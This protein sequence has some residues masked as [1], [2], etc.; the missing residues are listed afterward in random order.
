MSIG[1]NRSPTNSTLSNRL[2]T[3]SR[4]LTIKLLIDLGLTASLMAALA[5]H[6][7]GGPAHEV[8]GLAM[9]ILLIA[10]NVLNWR[11]YKNLGARPS[12]PRQF[13]G[14]TVTLVLLA[15]TVALLISSIIVSRVVFDF[16]LVENGFL[17]RQIHT[18][19]AYWVLVLMSIHVG[20]HWTMIMKVTGKIFNLGF[21]RL[22]AAVVRL[23]GLAVMV[24]GVQCSFD[25]GLGSKLLMRHSFDFW[26]GSPAGFFIS[27]IMIMGLYIG[28][29]HYSL[30]FLHSG[31]QAF[32]AGR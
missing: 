9:F 32:P 19:A 5:Y 1:W 2:E 30:K 14:L 18:L 20:L 28:L 23:A 26:E 12:G 6:L 7:T 31:K 17:M 11:W 8:I 29:T 25:R 15:V 13:L 27:Y 4:K 22:R 10:H 16:A 21:S 3:M 24:G